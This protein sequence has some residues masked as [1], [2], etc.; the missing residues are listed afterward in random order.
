MGGTGEGMMNEKDWRGNRYR[1]R[2][3][4]RIGKK[5]GGMTRGTGEIG[6]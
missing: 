1:E 4:R 3:I 2:K 6:L 5:M